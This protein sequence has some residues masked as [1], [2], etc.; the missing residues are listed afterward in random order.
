M[1]NSRDGQLIVAL[2][3]RDILI[4]AFWIIYFAAGD[5]FVLSKNYMKNVAHHHLNKLPI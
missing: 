3:R 2:K 4:K 5:E 1:W